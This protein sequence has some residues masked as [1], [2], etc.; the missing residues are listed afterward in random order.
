[1]I[2]RRSVEK[3]AQMILESTPEGSID[4]DTAIVLADKI[5]D[6]GLK[7]LWGIALAKMAKDGA[8]VYLIERGMEVD[9][10]ATAGGPVTST[11]HI[12]QAIER[13]P[14]EY[15]CDMAWITGKA[16]GVPLDTLTPS[17]PPTEEGTGK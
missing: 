6:T 16:Q 2:L 3:I 12:V 5:L 15:G 11:G 7:L 14:N 10:H 8:H 13:V 4:Y 17:A 1:M 9:Y